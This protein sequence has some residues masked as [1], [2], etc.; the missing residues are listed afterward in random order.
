MKVPPP[1]KAV[2]DSFPLTTYPPVPNTT[3]VKKHQQDSQHYYFQSTNTDGNF[4]LG[5]FNII[6]VNNTI[7]P[8]DPLSCS[9]AFILANINQLKLPNAA[10]TPSN[11]S[12]VLLSMY[13]SPNEQLPILIEDQKDVRSIKTSES[14]DTLI[15][16]RFSKQELL[17]N[18]LFHNLYDTWL[19]CL[20]TEDVDWKLVFN[21]GNVITDNLEIYDLLQQLPNW[22]HFRIRNPQLFETG[23]N[24]KDYL[25][26][27]NTSALSKYYQL[28]LAQLSRQLPL[29]IAYDST[30]IHL[31]LVAYT[32]TI[33][34]T[35]PSTELGKLFKTDEAFLSKCYETLAS[36]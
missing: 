13:S 36:L 19:L 26:K 31:K 21:W 32:V 18:E 16:T 2:F 28:K 27:K 10:N 33:V 35:L 5:I 25:K 14:V 6:T 24:V 11:C 9:T 23:Y 29:L 8:S 34:E 1:I 15:E 22:K 3:P 17:V 7:I 4:S 12:L 30:L 20:L